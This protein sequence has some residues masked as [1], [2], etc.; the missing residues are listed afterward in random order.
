MKENRR[1]AVTCGL[2]TLMLFAALAVYMRARLEYAGTWGQT[3]SLAALFTLVAGGAMALVARLQK[4]ERG[5]L[6]YTALY[7]LKSYIKLRF[8]TA[9]VDPVA[10]QATMLSKAASSLFNAAFAFV[11]AP[12]FFNVL[13]KPLRRL[14]LY[15]K[16]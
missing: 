11:V 4:P 16:D 15:S 5:A 8:T 9:D 3:L 10:I 7:L 1:A 12:I 13:R 6:T 2:M 14:G